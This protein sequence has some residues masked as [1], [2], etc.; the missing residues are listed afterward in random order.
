MV[1][2][3]VDEMLGTVAKWLRIM[4]FDAEYA[5]DME[6]EEIMETAPRDGRI[7]LTRDRE[8]VERATKRGINAIYLPDAELKKDLRRI[9]DRYPPNRE[10]FMSRCM[11]CNSE[12]IS[13]DKER[14]KGKVPEGVYERHKNFWYCRNCDKYYWKG[15]HWKKIEEFIDFLMK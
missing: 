9:I 10:K 13:V 14:V 6:D 7:I 2:F 8:L 4:G 3:L 5:K 12:L 15:T 1:K 11:V